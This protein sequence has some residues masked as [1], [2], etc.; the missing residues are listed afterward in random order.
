M[1]ATQFSIVYDA[2]TLSIIRL[3]VPDD[4][5][6]LSDGTHPLQDGEAQIVEDIAVL[7]FPV[8]PDV[9]PLLQAIVAA[10]KS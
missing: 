3:V 6:A 7:P 10:K 8:T 2:E 1:A 9:I 4:D 5:A